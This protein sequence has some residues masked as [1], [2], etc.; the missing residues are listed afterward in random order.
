MVSGLSR[1]DL[2]A[3]ILIEP[4]VHAAPA[5]AV[6]SVRQVG[7]GTELILYFQQVQDAEQQKHSQDRPLAEQFIKF[8]FD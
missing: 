5:S 1:A 7:V 6:I 8:I 3:E 4:P 2:P